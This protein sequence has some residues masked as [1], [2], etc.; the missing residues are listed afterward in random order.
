MLK[1]AMQYLSELSN[2]KVIEINGRSFATGDLT[3]IN[4]P[5][6]NSVVVQSL[7]GLVDYLK[8]N[9]D[10]HGQTLIHV[11]DPQTVRVLSKT[12]SDMNRQKWIEAKAFVPSF[13]FNNF[14]D[15]EAFNIKL[16]STFVKNEDRDI[17]LKVVG[18]LREENVKTI[19]DDGISQSVSAKVG[20]ATVADVRVPN[21]V[22]LAPYRTF[23]EVEQPE[24][25][26]VLRM[27]DGGQC[28]L[29][30][31]DGG[32]WQ[33]EAMSNV[34]NFLQAELQDLIDNDEIYIIS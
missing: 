16:Q 28:A 20:I 26:F 31:A 13:N 3:S 7:S 18:N 1:E 9:F 10:A 17:V 8:S 29:F 24:S 32:A 19:G 6:V 34:A 23:T 33:L 14:Y 15:S 30:E 27:R 5:V 21:P 22:L 25:N 11:V 4:E 12:N 2:K